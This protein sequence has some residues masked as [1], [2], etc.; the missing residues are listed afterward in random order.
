M[1]F[2]FKATVSR[3]NFLCGFQS[4]FLKET[5]NLR[6]GALNTVAAYVFQQKE[7]QEC[8]VYLKI[9][10]LIKKG[11]VEMFFLKILTKMS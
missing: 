5:P 2:S 4:T 7:T 9:Y 3:N 1:Y 8:I 10:V 11:F 6:K